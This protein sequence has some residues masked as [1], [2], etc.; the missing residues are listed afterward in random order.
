MSNL[1]ADRRFLIRHA[2]AVALLIGCAEVARADDDSVNPSRVNDLEQVVVTAHT[3]QGPEQ[4]PSQGSLVAT[5]PQSIVSGEFIQQNLAPASNYTDIIALTPS[6]WTVDPNG[7]GL[8]ENLSTSIR[9]FQDGQFNV[10]F[11]GIP[12]G[13]SNDF[14]HH[15]TSY[16][17][18]MNIGDV[19]VDRGPGNASVLGDATFGGTVAVQSADPKR[20]RGFSAILSDGSFNTR[21]G[22]LRYDTGEISEWGGTSAF[23]DVQTV[24]SDGYLSNANLDRTNAFAKIVQPL[25]DST[26]ITFA[27]NL[28]KLAQNPPVGATQAQINAFG[29][30]FA[31]NTDPGTQSYYGYN[32][33]KITT[34]FEFIGLL[35]KVAGW[36]INNKLYT[37]A[38]YHD[39]WNGEDVYGTAPGGTVVPG[40]FPNG[41]LY[42]ADDVPGQRLTNNY[43]SVGDIFRLAHDFGPGEAQIGFWYDHQTNYRALIE[44]DFSDNDAYNPTALGNAGPATAQNSADRIMH[45]ALFTAQGYIQYEWHATTALD[46]TGGLKEVSFERVLDASVNQN[47]LQPLSYN[48]TWTRDLPSLD[49]HY[50]LADNWSAYA[51]WSKGFLAPNLNVLYSTN[52]A[53]SSTLN[54]E[55]TTNAQVGTAWTSRALTVAVDAYYINF[56]NL[57]QHFATG[58]GVTVFYNEGGVAYRGVEAEATYVLGAGFSVYGNASWN[59]AHLTSDDTW[60]PDAPEKT[61]ALGLFYKQGRLQGSVIDKYV[62]VRYGNSEDTI[63]QGGYSTT[64]AAVNYTFLESAGVVKKASIGFAIQNIFD[65]SSLYYWVGTDNSGDS[66]WF[67]VPGRSFQV[68]L[69]A[70]L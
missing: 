48:K 51:Q 22:S 6:V 46:V 38:Y 58:E 27:S 12:W 3:L 57:I 41:T 65:N 50:K 36:T 39:G 64:E 44:E 62:G 63:R 32:L 8:M 29:S 61:A 19:V 37:Y 20:D 42:G 9:G 5:E 35:S 13:D 2:V 18:A 59:S 49:V 11:D 67:R 56:N 17:M 69:T 21:L 68:T 1:L 70:G 40:E 4:S 60:V 45:D 14:T 28:N 15:S 16:F 43:R 23:L 55:G 34:D 25:G 26:T 7:P 30:N 52:P 53:Q 10:T 66:V 33:D 47:T 24:S 54:P 31:Y